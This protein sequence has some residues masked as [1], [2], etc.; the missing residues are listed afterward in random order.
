MNGLS[1]H[2]YAILLATL[3]GA[4]IPLGAWAARFETL[5]P[6]WLTE[7]FRHTVI[8]FGGG[9]LFSAVAL[10]LV[11]E[12]SAR[13]TPPVTLACF[14]AGGVVFGFVDFLLARS[15]GKDS[16]FLAMML[17]YLPEAMALGAMLAGDPQTALLLA[18]LIALQNLPESFN[19]WREMTRSAVPPRLFLVFLLMVPLGPIAAI[20][21][22]VVL[23]ETP[24][25]LGM[26]MVFSAGGILYLIFEDVAPQVPLEQKWGPPLGAVAG[27]LLGLAGH[28]YAV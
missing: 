17:D 16:Q 10:V 25:A 19:A 3:A 8:A 4:S 5:L 11:P 13:L 12:G 7:E 6:G 27:F 14:A 23:A 26:I 2:V 15:G 1:P 22:L 20:L 24:G 28:L 9:A 21:G 18:G